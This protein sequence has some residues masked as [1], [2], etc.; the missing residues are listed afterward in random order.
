MNHLFYQYETLLDLNYA[1]PAKWEWLKSK[2]VLI[3]IYKYIDISINVQK[4]TNHIK[5]IIKYKTICYCQS[6]QITP[7]IFKLLLLIY[8]IDNQND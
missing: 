7:Y 1:S 5:P 4:S 8:F 6:Y 3:V 2:K